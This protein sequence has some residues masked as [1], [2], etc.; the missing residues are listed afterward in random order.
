MP[1]YASDWHAKT[2]QNASW[3]RAEAQKWD[4]LALA[5]DLDG[6]K[7][8]ATHARDEAA[9]CRQNARLKE[10]EEVG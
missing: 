3:W 9:Q 5:A 7:R 8:H 2:F 1:T 6:D 10:M 4:Q